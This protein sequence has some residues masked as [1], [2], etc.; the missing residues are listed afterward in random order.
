MGLFGP[1]RRERILLEWGITCPYRSGSRLRDDF[2]RETYD[3]QLREFE[4][5]GA[6]SYQLWNF[7]GHVCRN[8]E[9]AK[10]HKD[11][12]TLVVRILNLDNWCKPE[13]DHWVTHDWTRL[14]LS[15]AGVI[16]CDYQH[17]ANFNIRQKDWAAADRGTMGAVSR[18]LH[19]ITD[20][21]HNSKEKAKVVVLDRA[22]GRSSWSF[23]T[24]FVVC[25]ENGWLE[26]LLD[27]WR[28]EELKPN[29]WRERD[30]FLDVL[31]V[32]SFQ[33][34]HV[35]ILEWLMDHG[36]SDDC[37]WAIGP[38]TREDACAQWDSLFEWCKKRNFRAAFPGLYYGLDQ[39]TALKVWESLFDWLLQG[40]RFDACMSILEA[41]CTPK[42]VPEKWSA[43]W[44]SAISS[45]QARSDFEFCFEMFRKMD[46]AK[47][48]RN[49]ELLLKRLVEREMFRELFEFLDL[50]QQLKAPAPRSTLNELLRQLADHREFGYCYCVDVLE[51]L[52]RY[53]D[54]AELLEKLGPDNSPVELSHYHIRGELF[55]QRLSRIKS[56]AAV[57][58]LRIEGL[59]A[60]SGNA[61]EAYAYGEISKAEYE[62]LRPDAA[63]VKTCGAC[64]K[65]VQ[66]AFAFC[67]HCG[68]KT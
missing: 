52:G 30:H 23:E 24:S 60:T 29:V 53:R 62:H 37:K 39:P 46:R 12:S 38:I 58:S 57:T 14:D 17:P 61:D 28:K 27:A 40:Y 65:P 55:A 26:E 54:A 21:D 22:K 3:E 50:L 4:R 51:R 13:G 2:I 11:F 45:A 32:L 8:L 18:L 68:G 64:G 47:I 44:E 63:P 7:W 48:D 35:R 66:P 43:L 5:G 59:E 49:R 36:K 25:E 42:N 19:S 15:E 9:H 16:S 31:K 33:R 10:K 6:D 34:Q 56:L 41:S 20:L 1:S 67:P